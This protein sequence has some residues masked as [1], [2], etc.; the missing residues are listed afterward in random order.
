MPR[1]MPFLFAVLQLSDAARGLSVAQIWPESSYRI[2][3]TPADA[4]YRIGMWVAVVSAGL[5]SASE[6]TTQFLPLCFA[7]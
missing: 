6:T 3:G 4:L 7:I 1:S 5:G 2:F